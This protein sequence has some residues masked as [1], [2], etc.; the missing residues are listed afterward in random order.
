MDAA[1]KHAISCPALFKVLQGHVTGCT[2]LICKT[3]Q[4]GP[5]RIQRDSVYIDYLPTPV[6]PAA[7]VQVVVAF[8]VL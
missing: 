4:K 5:D 2:G 3:L 6:D 1:Y 7:A 8:T